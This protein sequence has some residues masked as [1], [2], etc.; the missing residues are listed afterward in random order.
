[1]QLFTAFDT[2]R[3]KWIHNYGHKGALQGHH[4]KIHLVAFVIHNYNLWVW[5]KSMLMCLR[6]YWMCIL[7]C[8]R[9]RQHVQKIPTHICFSLRAHSFSFF[10]SCMSVFV[11][12]LISRSVLRSCLPPRSIS[13]LE[14]WGRSPYW[15][16]TCP[17]LSLDRGTM[18][19]SSTSKATRTVSRLW[20]STAPAY[21]VKRPR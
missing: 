4:A 12:F 13:L 9:R 10:K 11:L 3:W 2:A 6:G 7:F 14:L 16:R 15:P 1:M 20:G 19:V 8:Q 5:I 18:S 21:S 17:S